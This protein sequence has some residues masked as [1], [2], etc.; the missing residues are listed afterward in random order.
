VPLFAEDLSGHWSLETNVAGRDV[1][2]QMTLRQDGDSLSGSVSG[3][4]R[5]YPIQR[6]SVDSANNVNI[7]LGGEGPLAGATITGTLNGDRLR[8]TV[9]TKRGEAEGEAVRSQ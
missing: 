7:L 1:T 3:P 6:G 5:E 9:H 4:R 8:L 2:L